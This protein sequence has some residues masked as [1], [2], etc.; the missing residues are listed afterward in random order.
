M[1]VL[2][3]QRHETFA[4]AVANRKTQAQAYELA[5]YKVVGKAVT[6][7]AAVASKI[8]NRKDVADRIK[9]LAEKA[10]NIAEVSLADLINKAEDARIMAMATRNPS[11]AVSAIREMGVLSGKRIQ[12]TE[13]GAPGEFDHLSDEQLLA[14]LQEEAQQIALLFD[15]GGNLVEG[16]DSEQ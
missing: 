11:A 14:L 9:E 4:H 13:I 1:P 6:S 2:K 15:A 10:A 5:G 12:R 16:P 3:N 8:A 7:I